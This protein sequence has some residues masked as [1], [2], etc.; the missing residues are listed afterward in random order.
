MASF[1]H[2]TPDSHLAKIRRNGIAAS[3]L[4]AV[5][6]PVGRGVF[7]FPVL[8]DFFA[9]HQWLHE[10]RRRSR[11]RICGVYFRVA[12]TQ[13]VYIG[14]FGTPHHE[15]SAAEACARLGKDRSLGMEVILPRA[16]GRSEILSVRPLPQCVGWRIY[17]EA[18]GNPP[19]W[20]QPGSF[21]ARALRDRLTKE[22]RREEERYVSR[23]PAEWYAE[24]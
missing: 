15:V 20:P 16:I 8:P 14:R 18:K 11:E 10:L 17:P 9:T 22:D 24:E 4:V 13:R 21:R 6:S 23:F 1:V 12:D 3:R 5:H 19:V 7:C 2:L